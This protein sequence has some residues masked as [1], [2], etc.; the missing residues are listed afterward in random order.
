MRKPKRSEFDN[1]DGTYD[2][3]GFNEVMGDYEDSERDREL[4]ERME[5]TEERER[6]ADYSDQ[7][8]T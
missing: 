4:E 7:E 6:H 8:V 1:G 5:R 3:D 2:H